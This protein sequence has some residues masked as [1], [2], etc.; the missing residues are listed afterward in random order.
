MKKLSKLTI[1]PSKV[2]KNEELVNLKGGYGYGTPCCNCGKGR[3]MVGSTPEDCESDCYA[4][5]Y[6]PGKWVC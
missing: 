2:M 6:Y 4:V 5:Y 3:W 1:N